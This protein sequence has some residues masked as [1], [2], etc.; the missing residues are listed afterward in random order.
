MQL[1]VGVLLRKCYG[2]IGAAVVIHHH[3]IGYGLRAVQQVP[4][5]SLPRFYKQSQSKSAVS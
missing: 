1:H 5:Y 4:D 3:I 2:A